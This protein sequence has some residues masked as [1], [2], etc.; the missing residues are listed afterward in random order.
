MSTFAGLVTGHTPCYE[1]R[2]TARN[3]VGLLLGDFRGLTTPQP[4]CR[5]LAYGHCGS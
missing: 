5:N 2:D 4:Q 3:W 1:T